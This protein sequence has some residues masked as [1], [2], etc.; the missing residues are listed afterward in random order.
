MKWKGGGMDEPPGCDLRQRLVLL[1]RNA[2]GGKLQLHLF[3]SSGNENKASALLRRGVFWKFEICLDK[4]MQKN[5]TSDSGAAV[6]A[7]TA[8]REKLVRPSRG[9]FHPMTRIET[10]V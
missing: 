3:A 4:F 10:P 9:A 1:S 2:P 7:S 6:L 8:I 5:A